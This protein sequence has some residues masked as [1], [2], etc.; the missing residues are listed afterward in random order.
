MDLMPQGTQK[1][2]EEIQVDVGLLA[3]LWWVP[4]ALGR[5]KHENLTDARAAGK[6]VV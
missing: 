1:S 5:R 4:P 6:F 3:T 2:H